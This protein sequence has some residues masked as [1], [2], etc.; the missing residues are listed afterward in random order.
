[1]SHKNQAICLFTLAVALVS[2]SV[3]NAA[4]YYVATTGN[5]TNSGTEVSPWKTIK[6][7]VLAMVAGDTTYVRG[8]TYGQ[9]DNL[10]FRKS[11]TASAPIRL[12]NYP[13]EKPKI[14]FT[15]AFQGQIMLGT[16]FSGE[17]LVPVGWIVIEGF[18]I[19]KGIYGFRFTNAHDVTVRRNWIHDVSGQGIL[20]HGKNVLVDGNVIT[21]VGMIYV[22]NCADLAFHGGGNVCNKLHGIYGTGTNWTITN[23]LIYDNLAYGIQVAAYPWCAD[24]NC[25]GGGA[26]NK[27]DP[28]YADAKNWLI[29]NNTIAYNNYRGGMN[30]WMG[31]T[32]NS[33]I[34]NNVFYENSQRRGAE[35]QG[36]DIWGAGGG[37]VINNNLFYASG[38]G[39]TAAI[40][41]SAGWESKYTASGNIINGSP[42]LFVNAPATV[43]ASPNFRLTAA[44]P[45]IDKGVTLSGITTDHAGGMRPF[46][47][48]FDIGAYE[49]GGVPVVDYAPAAPKNFA[50]Q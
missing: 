31:G 43:P 25:Y 27:A 48:G 26:K 37:N 33:K 46:G 19:T 41:G 15:P 17:A 16:N 13:G 30:L 18:E 29:A 12:L 49:F 42:P 8:G 2:S 3:V 38:P 21:R 7:A 10:I 36:V 44:S 5:D 23:N 6:R 32:T 24:G 9:S 47:A 34:I 35:P 11:G 1:M 28:S 45:A 22:N 40:G 4:N 14:D 20:G 50:V 39:G